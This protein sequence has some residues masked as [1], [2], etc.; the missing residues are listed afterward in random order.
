[1]YCTLH[2]SELHLYAAHLKR[3]GPDDRRLRFSIQA[4]DDWIDRY[5]GNINMEKDRIKVIFDHGKVVAAIH[6]GVANDLAEVGVSVEK[7]YRKKGWGHLLFEAATTWCRNKGITRMET[8]CLGENKWM[9]NK[10]REFNSH[11]ERDGGQVIADFT[12]PEN[13][14]DV[15]LR[16]TRNSYFGFYRWLVGKLAV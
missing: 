1:M 14:L 4:K 16:E 2:K 6:I 15:Q 13:T 10:V 3:L 12:I 11:F 5:V 9:V 7:E 8:V